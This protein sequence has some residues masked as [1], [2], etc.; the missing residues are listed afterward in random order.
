VSEFPINRG[1]SPVPATDAPLMLVTVAGP[2]PVS[3]V[4]QPPDQRSIGRRSSHA[5]V[6]DHPEVSKD[7]AALKFHDGQRR[8]GWSIVDMGSRHGTRV[9]GVALAA[10]RECPIAA[11]DLIEISPWTFC[12]M[13]QSGGKT[14]GSRV[15]TVDDTIASGSTVTS[16]RAEGGRELAQER[17]RLLLHCAEALQQ[18]R[19]EKSLAE[20]VLNAAIAGTGYT[21]AA[22]TRPMT[23]DGAI[24]L[25]VSHGEIAATSATPRVSRS[26]IKAAGQGVAAQ[27]MGSGRAIREAVSIAEFGI[28]EAICVP[29]MIESTIAGFLYL[30]NCNRMDGGTIA[31]NEAC[32]FA[33]GIGRLAS[34]AWANLMRL[35][36]ERRYARM[37]GELSAAA[38]AQQ[39][40]LPRRQGCCG[41]ISYIGECK[42][43]RVV[44]GDFFDVFALPD[45]RVAVT[46]G[47]VA[48][49]GIAASVVMTTAQGFLHGA[50]RQHGDLARAIHELNHYVNERCES[51]I[52]VTMW[53]GIFDIAAGSLTYTDA[54]HGYA[55]MI[56]RNGEMAPL[57]GA[58]G[59]PIAASLDARFQSGRIAL[60]E[61]SRLLLVS[62]GIIEQPAPLRT[63]AWRDEFGRARV[64]QCVKSA[65]AGRDEVAELFHAVTA[66][67]GSNELADDATVVVARW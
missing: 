35:E 57:D 22:V 11:G 42:P 59:P 3:F 63:S 17:L 13:D 24:E 34:M 18:A 56:K 4:L 39:L 38:R 26:L 10:Q 55:W 53:A 2:K 60:E 36:L 23:P 44:S 54:G 65:I 14:D 48:G 31:G 61:G 49:K 45:N 51:Q 15:K 62:D 64:E 1:E 43:G 37:E 50:L 21:N 41:G 16:I 29:L 27:L 7:H 47:D 66:H 40:I 30:D 19:D 52:F 58:G 9:N 20:I 32:A 28:Q 8:G 33:V 6:L 67:A 12:L 5:L 46:I 25:I